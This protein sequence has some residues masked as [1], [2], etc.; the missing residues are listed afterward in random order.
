MSCRRFACAVAV[1]IAVTTSGISYAED[2]NDGIERSVIQQGFEA[3]PIP[4]NKL[5]FAGK[6][7]LPGGAWCPSCQ[8]CG[9][10]QRLPFF[11]A[12]SPTG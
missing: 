9:R 1:S 11:S 4:K 6:N 12:I 3:S 10:L 7:P 2:A 5:N 8:C